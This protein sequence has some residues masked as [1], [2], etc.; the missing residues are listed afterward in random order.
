MD[1][2]I[3]GAGRLGGTLA[4]L[5][6][7]VGH[8][9][10]IANTKG[11]KSLDD[12]TEMLGSNL[13]AVTPERAIQFGEVVILAVPFRK[14]DTLPAADHFEEKIV[15]DATNPYTENFHVIDLGDRTSSEVI[16]SQLPDARVVKAFN[17]IYWETLRD[18]GH[19]ELSESERFAIFLAGDDADA[20]DVVAGLIRD[21]GFGA[22]DAGP[23][24]TGGALLEPGAALYNREISTE[25]ARQ[26]TQELFARR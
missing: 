23:L 3:L 21:L 15:V 26:K 5:L 22:V 8:E 17:T 25:E 19:P 10:A 16:A 11:P 18:F 20:K 14:R 4:Q 1:I 6:V 7:E 13:H 2:G 12:L 24:A 9:V